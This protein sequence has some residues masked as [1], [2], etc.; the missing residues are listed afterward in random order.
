MSSHIDYQKFPRS[1]AC[2][3]EG[4]RAR[5]WY[6]E[7]GK[8]FCQRGH[9]QANFTQTQQ[10][11][12]DWNAQGK[13]TRKLKEKQEKEGLVVRGREAVELYLV[14]FGLVL[15]KQVW[16]LR[17][18]KGVGGKLR[19]PFITGESDGGLE[20]VVRALWDLKLRWLKSRR[21]EEMGWSTTSQSEWTDASERDTEGTERS[22]SSRRS[23]IEF[24]E[25]LPKLMESLGLICVAMLMMRLPFSVGEVLDWV[26]KG[27]LIFMRAIKEIPKEMRMKLPAHYHKALETRHVPKGAK[28]HQAILD[29][30]RFYNLHFE[31]EFPPL[32]TPLVLY[33]HVRDLCLPS[34]LL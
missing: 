26:I 11:E 21:D 1:E 9:E 33:K 27:D 5:K 3:E 10:D 14:C 28:L 23:N 2:S 32:N 29:T 24:K 20:E 12:D 7:A 4:C 17:E 19:E 16:W 34:K 18:V 31:M 8:K 13:K 15:W 22:F 30:I 6:I 25:R